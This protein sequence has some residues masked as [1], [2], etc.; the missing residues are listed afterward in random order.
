MTDQA[1]RIRALNDR[2][3]QGDISI[4]GRTMMTAGVQALLA[5]DPA[6]ISALL[7]SIRSFDAFTGDNDPHGEHDFAAI[8]YAREKLFWKIDY[9]AP[10][11]EHGSED[12]ANLSIT[13]RVMTIML[14]EEY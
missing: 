13:V 8:E 4:P 1:K 5:G 11:L 6:R 12:P 2:F 14:A 3:R 9:Y 7:A 10:D